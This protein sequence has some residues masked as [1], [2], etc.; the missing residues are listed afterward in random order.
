MLDVFIYTLSDPITND[1][2]YIGKT[3]DVKFRFNDHIKK[4]K[5]NKTHKDKWISSLLNKGLK[6][7]ISIIDT[8]HED[9]WEFW[10]IF[11][12]SLFKTWGFN[13]VN[14]TEGGD[15]GSFKEHTYESKMKMSKSR[16][17]K[18]RKPFTE[19]HRKNLSDSA[20]KKIITKEHRINIKNSLKNIVRK[21][22]TEDHKKNISESK[23][24]LVMSEENKM[25]IRESSPKKKKII[26]SE[27]K[28]IYSSISEASRALK[29]P[30]STIVGV[31]KKR[32]NNAKGFKFGYHE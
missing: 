19:E 15:G 4:S 24:G 25:K 7:L 9:G 5:N 32:R 28:E 10:E 26:C 6:P 17:G 12:I 30:I 21:P 29:I 22:F 31:L 13:L 3:N 11:Y 20:K 27:T 16:F 8:V 14:H 18:S 1:V 2:R 23:K